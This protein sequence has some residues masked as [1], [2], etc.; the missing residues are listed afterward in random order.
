MIS[1]ELKKDGLCKGCNHADIEVMS[2]YGDNGAYSQLRC[3]HQNAC[4][5]A[6]DIGFRSRESVELVEELKSFQEY[7]DQCQG[8]P[9]LP[10]N[11]GSG[12]CYCIIGGRKWT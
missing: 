10:A 2:V 9:N 3:S 1:I 11:G 6:Y 7:P 12:V 5:R 8:C 4:E